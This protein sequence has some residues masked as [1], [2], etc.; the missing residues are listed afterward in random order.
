M[1][2]SPFGTVTDTV[3][4]MQSALQS[5]IHQNLAPGSVF[6]NGAIN[7]YG[8]WTYQDTLCPLS[9]TVGHGTFFGQFLHLSRPFL[10]RLTI[11]SLSFKKCDCEPSLS[12]LQLVLEPRKKYLDLL[13]LLSDELV[14]SLEEGMSGSTYPAGVSCDGNVEGGVVPLVQ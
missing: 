3:P 9:R 11:F 10:P 1:N 2:G 7:R 12:V 14:F 8:H 5:G 4:L 6:S 13:F